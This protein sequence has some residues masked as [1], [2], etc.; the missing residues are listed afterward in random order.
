MTLSGLVIRTRRPPASTNVSVVATSVAVLERLGSLEENGVRY[1]VGHGTV[2]LAGGDDEQVA[3]AKTHRNL[4]L[5]VDAELAVPAEEQLVLVVMVPLEGALEPRD[6][7]DCVVRDRQVPRRPRPGECCD[8]VRDRSRHLHPPEGSELG[9]DAMGERTDGVDE[10]AGSIFERQGFM[11]T[12]GAEL[13][14]VEPG[15]VV[16][17]MVPTD[18]V[19]Q[20]DGFVHAAAIAGLLDTVCGGA[21][22]TLMSPG[23]GVLTVEYKINLLAPARGDRIVGTGLVIRTGRTISVCRGEAIAYRGAEAKTV[24]VMQATMMAVPAGDA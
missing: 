1:V 16:A 15:R 18:A 19:T 4:T 10:F 6:P 11:R 8:R 9:S 14:E 2:L 23:F 22:Y 7:H 20:Q 5:E 21:A 3:G 12:I 13:E 24:A 17:S